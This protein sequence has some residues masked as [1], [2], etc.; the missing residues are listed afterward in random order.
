MMEPDRPQVPDYSSF[1]W[2]VF[3]KIAA[4][5]TTA[6]SIRPRIRHLREAAGGSC[7]DGVVD[8]EYRDRQEAAGGV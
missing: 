8:Y 3:W 5:A 4:P 1:L 6:G 7:Q 2:Q